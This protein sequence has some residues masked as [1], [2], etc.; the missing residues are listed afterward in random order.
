MN[1]DYLNYSVLIDE[2]PIDLKLIS[3]KDQIDNY[4]T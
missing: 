2:D 1:V 4:R 3:L